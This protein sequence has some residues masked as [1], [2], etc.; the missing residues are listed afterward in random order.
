MRAYGEQRGQSLANSAVP[1]RAVR[2]TNTRQT[3]IHTIH[4]GE[5]GRVAGCITA[6]KEQ[7]HLNRKDQVHRMVHTHL[8]SPTLCP[9]TLCRLVE[10]PGPIFIGYSAIREA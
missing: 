4:G 9:A 7:I 10:C 1:E 6:A 5:F 3:A 8:R 2:P